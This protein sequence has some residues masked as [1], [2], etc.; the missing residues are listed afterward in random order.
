MIAQ[1][2]ESEDQIRTNR[3]L[4]ASVLSADVHIS[5]QEEQIDNEEFIKNVFALES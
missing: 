2:V 1:K 5:D 3:D 4:N